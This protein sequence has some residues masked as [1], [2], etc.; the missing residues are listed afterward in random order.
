MKLG[1]SSLVPPSIGF[2]W[3]HSTL[4][5]YYIYNY[6]NTKIEHKR[7]AKRPWAT[8][9]AHGLYKGIG[10]HRLSNKIRVWVPNLS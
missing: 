9:Y 1:Q 8:I 3:Q 5:H 2:L 4:L 10:H 6:N 7:S